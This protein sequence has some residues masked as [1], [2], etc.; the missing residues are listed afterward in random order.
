MCDVWMRVRLC[1]PLA[2]YARVRPWPAHRGIELGRT[3]RMPR[4]ERSKS[5]RP[6]SVPR[7]LC[8]TGFSLGPRTDLFLGRLL[9]SITLHEEN[10]IV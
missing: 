10:L 3:W 5:A 2:M 1:P 4:R 8:N 6:P 7:S 9:T